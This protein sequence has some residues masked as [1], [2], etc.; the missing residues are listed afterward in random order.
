MRIVQL[1][2]GTGDTFYCDNCLRDVALARALRKHGHDVLMIPMYLPVQFGADDLVGDVPIFFGGVNVYLQQ[3]SGFFRKTPRWIDRLLDRPGLLRWVGR[4][5]DMTSAKDLGQMTVSMLKGEHGRQ[6]KELERLV[7]WLS[8]QDNKPDIVCVSNA[9]L[10]GL[11]RFIRTRLDVPVLCLLQD[12]DGFLDALTEPY[13]EQAWDLLIERTGDIDEFVA[14]SRYY[15]EVMRKRL[16]ISA[17]RVHVVYTG[18]PLDGYELA[19]TKPQVPAIGFLSRMCFNKG[20]DTL[21]DAF[22]QLKKNEKLKHVRLRIAGG[23]SPGDE[24]FINRIRQNLDTCGLLGDVDFLTDFDRDTKLT[25][26]QT[27]SVL[28]VPER[29]AAA[30]SLYALEA[31]AAGVP[32]VAPA[33]GIFPELLEITG[34]G[35][36]FEPNNTA[37]LTAGLERLLLET[38]YAR[39]LGRQG[40]EAVFGKFNVDQTAKDIIRICEGVVRQFPRGQENA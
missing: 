15:A 37:S 39:Q 10:A 17:D 30:Y 7:N 24:G 19:D 34:G 31:L 13:S 3:K 1:T 36:L 35:I 14:V 22:I 11:A 25:F 5:S 28:S 8:A 33:S 9:L 38:D 16:S 32:I 40:R 29:Q 12:E 4:R 20:L 21:V 18:I 2:P 23:K 26:L 6:A 27:L